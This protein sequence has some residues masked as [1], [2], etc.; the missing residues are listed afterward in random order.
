MFDGAEGFVEHRSK[1]LAHEGAADQT[2]AMF[3]GKC[4]AEFEDEVSNFVGDG[5][6]FSQAFGGLHV[7]DG[8]HMEAADGGVGI[9]AGLGFV[10]LNNGEEAFDIVAQLFG[11]DGSVFHEGEGFGVF[12]HGHGEAEGGFAEGPDAGL[13]GGV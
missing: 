7:D 5:F 4:A 12:L 8:A 9:D 3:A 13:I 2:I 1:H 6:E 11:C 10:P